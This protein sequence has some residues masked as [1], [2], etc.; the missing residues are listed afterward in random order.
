MNKRIKRENTCDPEDSIPVGLPE[1]TVKV[2]EFPRFDDLTDEILEESDDRSRLGEDLTPV[3][4]TPAP[5]NIRLSVASETGDTGPEVSETS[6]RK[7]KNQRKPSTV[8]PPV[9]GTFEPLFTP[10]HYYIGCRNDIINND[11]KLNEVAAL[12]LGVEVPKWREDK[13]YTT[14]MAKINAS[15][16]KNP[17]LNKYKE[18]DELLEDVVFLKRHE[19]PEVAEKR[20]KKWD[21]QRLREITYCEKLKA[22][23]HG[24]GRNKKTEPDSLLPMPEAAQRIQISKEGKVP[25]TAFGEPVPSLEKTYF[26]LPWLDVKEEKSSV[27]RRPRHTS[28]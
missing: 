14:R 26:S 11:D 4:L 1:K 25:V 13:D 10:Y 9:L 2:S 7:K 20:Q 5:A 16:K 27:Q 17:F 22:R 21:I 8:P 18:G 15:T 12:Q 24:A 28:L 19:K 3:E 6:E 23:Q